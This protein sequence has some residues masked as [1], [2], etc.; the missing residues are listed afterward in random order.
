MGKSKRKVIHISLYIDGGV[1]GVC[2]EICET[3]E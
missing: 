2:A 3:N 1:V